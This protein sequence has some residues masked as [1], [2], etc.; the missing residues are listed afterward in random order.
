MTNGIR[1]VS[2]LCA[3]GLVIGGLCGCQTGRS[4]KPELQQ[5][6]SFRGQVP[7]SG[8][9]LPAQPPARD[10]K[11]ILAQMVS[12]YKEAD[13]MFQRSSASAVIGFDKPASMRQDTLVS[14]QRKPAR[15]ALRVRDTV[16]GST[17]I[18]AD[19]T[20]IITYSG[21]DNA[22]I[23]RSVTGNLSDLCSRID[24]GNPQILSPLQFLKSGAVPDGVETARVLRDEVV[25]KVPSTVVEGEFSMVY[26]ADLGRRLFR[27]QLH[28]DRRAYTLWIDSKT[29][30]V[31]KSSVRLQWSG[32]V[33][34]VSGSSVK[35][36]PKVEITETVTG[37]SVN[38]KFGRDEFRF[39]P[40]KGAR[41]VFVESTDQ[42][43]E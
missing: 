26:A 23:R 20:S 1:G 8:G 21:I 39:T 10:A 40:P 36:T 33:K 24:R 11:A 7:P 15:L 30:L 2:G 13:G 5:Q 34:T 12:A 17:A 31:R 27:A 19:G 16:D 29:H 38:P 6:S 43:K 35:A 41:E 18:V 14:Y 32:V 42:A 9:L 37:Q 3:A 22:F 25:D 4:T 28:P